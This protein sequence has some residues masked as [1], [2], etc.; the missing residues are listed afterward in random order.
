MECEQS[1]PDWYGYSL[2][3]DFVVNREELWTD[4]CREASIELKEFAADWLRICEVPDGSE[5]SIR[6]E[7]DMNHVSYCD[8]HNLIGAYL[9][10]EGGTI[11]EETVEGYGFRSEDDTEWLKEQI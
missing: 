9:F 7:C 6:V 5:A 2:K 4:L 10:R 3:F 8:L 1:N 11:A